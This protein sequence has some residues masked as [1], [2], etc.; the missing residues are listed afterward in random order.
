[1]AL[2]LRG[3]MPVSGRLVLAGVPHP[4]SVHTISARFQRTIAKESFTSAIVCFRPYEQGSGDSLTMA[5]ASQHAH[6]LWHSPLVQS[7]TLSIHPSRRSLICLDR[8]AP[9]MK[10][11]TAPASIFSKE[12]QILTSRNCMQTPLP[13]MKQAAATCPPHEA[14][15]SACP[16]DLRLPDAEE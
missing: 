3:I 10:L 14:I 12:N 5:G 4:C 8:R 7:P 13:A 6:S 1:M 9:P 16:H 11:S 2:L 15:D